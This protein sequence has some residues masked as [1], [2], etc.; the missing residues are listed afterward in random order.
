MERNKLVEEVLKEYER[1][2]KEFGFKWKLPLLVR[3]DI[4]EEVIDITLDKLNA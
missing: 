1:R 2:D 3:D 4:I